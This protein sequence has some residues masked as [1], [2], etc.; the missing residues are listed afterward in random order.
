MEDFRYDELENFLAAKKGWPEKMTVWELCRKS[1]SFD[2]YTLGIDDLSLTERLTFLIKKYIQ[3]LRILVKQ[4]ANLA[5]R[6]NNTRVRNISDI[7]TFQSCMVDLYYELVASDLLIDSP[8]AVDVG[9][10]IGQWSTSLL[11]LRP[12]ARLLTIEADPSTFQSLRSNLGRNKNVELINC[13]ISDTTGMAPF[14]RQPLSL[15]STL[16]PSKGD[17][18]DDFISVRTSTLDEIMLGKPDPDVVKIDIEGAELA[19]INGAPQTLKRTNILVVELSL[20][21]GASNAIE[22]LESIRKIVPSATI[23]KL[24]RPLG[25]SELPA[26]QDVVIRLNN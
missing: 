3:V 19:A 17:N 18:T 14:Y 22:V 23:V 26:C 1:V 2:I 10:N 15:M 20:A 7:G 11:V 4:D 6:N 16:E 24:G 21:R 13:A 12:N 9:A 8:Y 25:L 5:V